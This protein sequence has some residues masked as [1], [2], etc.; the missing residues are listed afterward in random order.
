MVRYLHLGLLTG[1]F[2]A[3]W[4]NGIKCNRSIYTLVKN[5]PLEPLNQ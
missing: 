2:R 4:K 1:K 5:K 3:D